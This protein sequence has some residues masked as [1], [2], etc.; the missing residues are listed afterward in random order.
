MPTAKDRERRIIW[1]KKTFSEADKIDEALSF[2]KLVAEI[3]L[4]FSCSLRTAREYM[5]ML[6]L[7]GYYKQDGDLVWLNK[8]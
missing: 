5:I 1:I 7:N 4:T 6:K 2:E 8:D 3:C